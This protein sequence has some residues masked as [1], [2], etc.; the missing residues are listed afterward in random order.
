MDTNTE[1]DI[2]WL[3][4]FD[5]YKKACSKLLEVTESGV[6]VEQLSELE[7]EGLIQRF[8]YTYELAWKVLQDY[9]QY[10]GFEF[11]TGPNGTIQLAFENGLIEDHG[12]WRA[13]SKARITTSH[14]YDEDDALVIV[15]NIFNVYSVILKQM[16]DL[17]VV[18]EKD[19]LEKDKF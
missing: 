1:R 13:M 8:E 7:R 17:L 18:K 9:L 14:T 19:A 2:R 12:A 6:S 3:Q 10:L 16:R 5:N 15:Q 4:R 11:Q